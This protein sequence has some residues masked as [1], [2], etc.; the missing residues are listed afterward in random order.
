M[1]YNCSSFAVGLSELC[2]AEK[3]FIIL[4]KFIFLGDNPL[5]LPF[6]FLVVLSFCHFQ[7]SGSDPV[8]VECSIR[9]EDGQLKKISVEVLR[10]DGL[11]MP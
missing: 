3:M 4:L 6:L 9:Q 8:D 2:I 11:A 10:T 7:F 5:S 1:L